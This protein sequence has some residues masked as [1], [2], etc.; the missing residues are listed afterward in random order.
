MLLSAFTTLVPFAFLLVFLLFLVVALASL[1]RVFLVDELHTEA[2]AG[3][4]RPV[5]GFFA[6][7]LFA[8]FLVFY[9]GVTFSI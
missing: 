5:F 1:V 9:R 2:P 8:L 7:L 6:M 3:L 4:P